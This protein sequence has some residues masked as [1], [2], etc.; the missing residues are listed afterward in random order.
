MHFAAATR[1]MAAVTLGKVHQ[2][3]TNPDFLSLLKSSTNIPDVPHCVPFM[4]G[5]YSGCSL[6]LVDVSAFVQKN[7]AQWISTVTG[8]R[9]K[10]WSSARNKDLKEIIWRKMLLCKGTMTA[11]L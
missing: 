3:H 6:C 8:C 11:P 4:T 1:I 9:A 5:H 2:L 10:Q 7:Q